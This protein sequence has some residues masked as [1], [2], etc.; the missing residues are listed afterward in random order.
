VTRTRAG[1]PLASWSA[2]VAV[3]QS[4]LHDVV[5]ALEEHAR[6]DSGEFSLLALLERAEPP[7]RASLGDLQRA[8]HPRYSQSGFSRLVQRMERDGLVARGPDPVDGRATTVVTT[9]VGRARYATAN[10]VYTDALR[11]AFGRHLRADEHATLTNLLEQL[12]I[13]RAAVE[14]PLS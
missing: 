11:R 9:R 12:M 2:L 5:G 13:V 1:D 14:D 8:M 10:A 3:Y 6:M 4:V 7:H